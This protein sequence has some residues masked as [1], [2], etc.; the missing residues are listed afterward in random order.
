MRDEVKRSPTI[1]QIALEHQSDTP[2]YIAVEF[3]DSLLKHSKLPTTRQTRRT[4]RPTVLCVGFMPRVVAQIRDGKDVT[5]ALDDHKVAWIFVFGE[6]KLHVV[7]PTH[8]ESC[9]VAGNH[10]WI[11]RTYSISAL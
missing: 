10:I 7:L 9:T 2:S 6:S 1:I 4:V 5:S 11:A 8:D 3:H